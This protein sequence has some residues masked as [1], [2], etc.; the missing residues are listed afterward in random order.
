MDNLVFALI[1]TIIFLIMIIGICVIIIVCK[2]KKYNELLTKKNELQEQ[3][4][5]LRDELSLRSKVNEETK[6]KLTELACGG[7][8]SALAILRNN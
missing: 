1:T 6:E 4:Y 7:I 5:K 3:L 8:N 2:H